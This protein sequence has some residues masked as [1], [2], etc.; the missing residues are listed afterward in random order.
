[1]H[2]LQHG[3]SNAP[4]GI[5]S[6]SG[7]GSVTFGGAATFAKIVDFETQV[8]NANALR[9]NPA[10][11]TTPNTRAKLKAAAK[12]GSTFPSF[13]WDNNMVNGYPAMATLQ[14]PSNKVIFGNFNDLIIADWI[15]MDVT[16][17]PYT[18]ADKNQIKITIN[19]LADIG[20]RNAGSFAASTDTGAA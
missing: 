3:T 19:M 4:V 15:G 18:L 5:L 6:T 14:V 1:M 16:V 13:I 8:S 12:I 7:I 20:V 9:L 10:Y 17:D 11:V 2:A